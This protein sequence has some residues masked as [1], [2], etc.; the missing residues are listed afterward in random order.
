MA[1]ASPNAGAP[2]EQDIHALSIALHGKEMAGQ[3]KGLCVDHHQALLLDPDASIL[4]S[5][6]PLRYPWL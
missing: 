2:Q 5:R 4:P 6:E 1:D 3:P